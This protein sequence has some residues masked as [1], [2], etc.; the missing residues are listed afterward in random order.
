MED[1]RKQL[2]K[3]DS[4]NVFDEFFDKLFNDPNLN[5]K[6]ISFLLDSDIIYHD[7]YSNLLREYFKDLNMNYQEL[8]K[9]TS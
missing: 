6:N 7:K 1:E 9:I 8:D 3:N 4:K 2:I 5:V